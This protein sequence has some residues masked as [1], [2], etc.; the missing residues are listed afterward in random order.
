[1]P[2]RRDGAGREG[3]VFV[4][5]GDSF[6]RYGHHPHVYSQLCLVHGLGSLA[7]VIWLT[8]SQISIASQVGPSDDG[9]D[10]KLQKIDSSVPKI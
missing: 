8:I 7:P 6:D 9:R 10:N 1:M 5:Q 3:K 2:D 4:L